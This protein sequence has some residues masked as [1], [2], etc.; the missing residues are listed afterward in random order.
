M[1]LVYDQV[2]V[3]SCLRAVLYAF[4][5]K[6]PLLFTSPNKPFRFDFLAAGTDLSYLKL[7]IPDKHLA[8]PCAQS[9]VGLPKELLWERIVFLLSLE[10][11]C[12]LSGMTTR[13]R[14]DDDKIVASNDY[15]KIVDIDFNTCHYFGDSNASGFVSKN[16][17][18]EDSYMCYD[19]IAFNSGGKHEV[20]FIHT[21]DDFVSEIWFYSSDRIDGN[22]PVRDACAVSRLTKKQLLDFDFS[23]TMARFKVVDIMKRNGMRGKFN[24]YTKKGTPR[25]YDFRTSGIERVARIEQP[26][27]RSLSA[28]VEAKTTTEKSLLESLQDAASSRCLFLERLDENSS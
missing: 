10:G 13:M 27:A 5:H 6:I 7:G 23:E 14:C 18:D 9:K 12:P 20:D 17:V 3:G 24:G 15:A 2:V 16:S 11:L 28:N 8:S 25:H 21:D 1:V 4:I 26:Q 19:Y 22:T